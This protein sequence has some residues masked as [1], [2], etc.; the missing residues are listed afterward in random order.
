MQ[1]DREEPLISE[2][3]DDALLT[4]QG[5][6]STGGSRFALLLGALVLLLVIGIAYFFTA[7]KGDNVP[8]PQP[9]PIVGNEPAPEP[10][11]EYAP[12]PDIPLPQPPAS[13]PNPLVGESV[14][15]Q[16]PVTLDISD[17]SVREVL[18]AAGSSE[19]YTNMLTN[20][21]LIQRST[22]V[23]DGM[24][25]GLVLN[26]ILPL[27]RPTGKFTTLELDGQSVIDPA[28][29]ARYDAYAQAAAE[30]DV[31][32]LATAFDSFRPL[33]EQ[34]Y[35]QLGYKAEDFDNTLIRA[36]DQ[37]A[38]TPELHQTIPLKKKEA[39]YLYADP[40]LEELA[41]LQ[42]QLLRMGPDNLALI[43]AQASALRAALLQQ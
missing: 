43:K 2:L 40:A 39:V 19:L 21:D 1:K 38:A 28:S 12:T 11:P 17:E 8:T 32:Q 29:Y 34:A 7:G 41:P 4:M 6:E 3:D 35:A 23:I 26:K 14:P 13:E 22:G 9:P 24:S 33:L 42:K 25:R 16:P 31:A 37:V 20:S 18:S 36:L 10:Q 30:L 27:P 15:A 5:G